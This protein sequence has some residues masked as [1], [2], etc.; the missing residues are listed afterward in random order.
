M[1]KFSRFLIELEMGKEKLIEEIDICWEEL[2]KIVEK[3]NK[4]KERFL[5][6]K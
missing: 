1:E 4:F 6:L 2:N 3:Y 5:V